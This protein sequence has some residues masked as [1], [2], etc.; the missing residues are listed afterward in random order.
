[1]GPIA[2]SGLNAL[3]FDKDGNGYVSDSFNGVIWKVGKHGGGSTMWITDSLLGNGTGSDAAVRGKRRRVQ[4]R[5]HDPVRRQHGVSPDHPD[6]CEL[7][8]RPGT[9]TIFISGINA[10]DGIAIDRDDNIWICANQEDE[11]VVVDK[12]GKVI[13][14]LGDFR[15]IDPKGIVRGLL[16]PASLAFSKDGKTLYVS[17]LT[18][19][20]PYADPPWQLGDQLG[21]DAAGQRLHRFPAS[22]QDTT[23]PGPRGRP[24]GLAVTAIDEVDKGC[25]KAA[26]SRRRLKPS[27]EA[28]ASVRNRRIT[29]AMTSRTRC[30]RRADLMHLRTVWPTI[31]LERR[32]RALSKS[33]AR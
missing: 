2:S 18:L 12:T 10:P 1:M 27:W 16:F 14:K 5:R 25:R 17:N 33:A 7:R 4:Q 31:A 15:G 3:T 11:I 32:C 6:S 29:K 19:Y 26:L 24:R 8:L 23:V 20:L 21:L 22:R 30:T 9:P 13:A 28:A